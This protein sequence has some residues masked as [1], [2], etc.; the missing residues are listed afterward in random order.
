MVL[1]LFHRP[2]L[3]GTEEIA[4]AVEVFLHD[5][6]DALRVERRVGELAVVGLVVGL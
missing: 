3:A 2:F 5:D 6:A 1:P 4:E